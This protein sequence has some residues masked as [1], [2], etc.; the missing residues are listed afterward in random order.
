MLGSGMANPCCYSCGEPFPPY[1]SGT[2]TTEIWMTVYYGLEDDEPA[3]A[4]VIC[5]QCMDRGGYD[6]WTNKREW[7]STTSRVLYRDL[8][9]LLD[10]DGDHDHRD[11][12]YKYPL[13]ES[14]PT[15]QS[16]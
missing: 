16:T 13:L 5:T 11:D 12:P 6:M 2:S 3:R 7:E 15:R 8:P 9:L 14:L 1:S 10:E 4:I